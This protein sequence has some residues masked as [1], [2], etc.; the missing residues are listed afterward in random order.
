MVLP[1]AIK[2]VAQFEQPAAWHTVGRRLDISVP[3]AALVREG[4]A[5]APVAAGSGD[6][7]RKASGV[8][9]S[10][11]P[12]SSR[13]SARAGRP[14]IE[15]AEQGFYSV[16]MQGITERRP[17]AVAVNLDPAESDLSPMAPQELVAMATGTGGATPDRG[18]LGA[19]GVDSGRYGEEA[20]AL[21]VP[22]LRRGRGAS[23]AKPRW[24]I[25][26]RGV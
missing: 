12:V 6:A 18:L 26:S 5:T 19:P 22:A 4:Q 3:L 24:P 8:V 9:V 23:V 7:G 1:D 11:Q 21:V 14:S 10:R 13:R 2:Y 17:F 16:R 20:G 25:G 15:L